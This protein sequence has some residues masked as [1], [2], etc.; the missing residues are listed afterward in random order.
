MD[1]YYD[2]LVIDHIEELGINCKV[3]SDP[4]AI[5]AVINNKFPFQGE[6]I[7]FSRLKNNK[8]YQSADSNSLSS[9]TVG[10][11]KTL[12][13]EKRLDEED[14]FIY[15]GDGLT[16]NGYEL[17]VKELLRIIPSII[18]DVPQHHY[19]I[20]K[21]FKKIIFISFE[22]A[23]EFGELYEEN[24]VMKIIPSDDCKSRNTSIL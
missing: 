4:S 7:D 6:R 10:F 17:S 14:T 8:F 22:Y 23:L 5:C 9:D 2:K 3:I 19:L 15:V 12:L 21:D 1:S 11:I 18:K 16:E 24:E 13:E 20:T